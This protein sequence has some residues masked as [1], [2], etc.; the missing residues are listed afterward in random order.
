MLLVIGVL[1]VPVV[2]MAV[3][4]PSWPLVTLAAWSFIAGVFALGL[5]RAS[6]AGDRQMTESTDDLDPTWQAFIIARERRGVRG[7]YELDLPLR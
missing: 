1:I 6:A 4:G 3:L 7:K 2:L 5:M